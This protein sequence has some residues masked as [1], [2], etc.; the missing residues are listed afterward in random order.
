M[1]TKPDD[2]HYDY[3]HQCWVEPVPNAP[4]THRVAR[5]GHSYIMVDCYACLHP[6]EPHTCQD[7]D[8]Y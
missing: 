1:A 2:Y 7:N 5:C 3:T 6:G 8:C 4:G